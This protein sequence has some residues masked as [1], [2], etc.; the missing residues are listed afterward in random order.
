MSVQNILNVVRVTEYLEGNHFNYSRSFLRSLTADC[1]YELEEIN[2]EA[3]IGGRADEI[4]F[5]FARCE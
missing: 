2:S 4:N 5:V 3:M 1:N